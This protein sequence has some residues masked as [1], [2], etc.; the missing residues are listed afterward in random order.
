MTLPYNY[1]ING[2]TAGFSDNSNNN[3][4]DE[5]QQEEKNSKPKNINFENQKFLNAFIDFYK[6]YQFIFEQK[7]AKKG[8]FNKKL[9]LYIDTSMGKMVKYQQ[10]IN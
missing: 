3:Q 1:I 10:R 8:L 5:T 4:S 6:K 9:P 7:E 2:M